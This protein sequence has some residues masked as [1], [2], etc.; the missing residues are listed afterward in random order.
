MYDITDG[1]KPKTNGCNVLKQTP[2]VLCN[3]DL[4]KHDQ[5]IQGILFYIAFAL[6][7]MDIV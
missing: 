1:D 6:F 7:L 5:V 2:V 3:I 4:I